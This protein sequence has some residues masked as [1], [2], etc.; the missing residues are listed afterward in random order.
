MDFDPTRAGVELPDEAL[1]KKFDVPAPRYTSYPTADRFHGRITPEDYQAALARREK[2][3]KPAKLSLY[4]HIPFCNDVCFY[5]GCNKIVTR[6]HSRSAAYIKTL[7]KEADLA[8]EHLTGIKTLEQLH[9]GGGTPTFLNDDEI[10][11]LMAGLNERFPFEEGGE[12]S[13]EVDPRSCPPSKIKTLRKAGFNRMSLG[14]QDFNPDV[15]KAVNR[16]QPFEM[17]KEVLESARAEGFGSINMDLIYGLPRQTRET[18]ARTIEQVI[19][20]SPDRIALYHYAHL[21]N[22]FKPQRRIIPA[23][24]PGAAERVN[25]MFDA[26]KT[27]T[28]HGYRYI[29]MDHF[30]KE[31]DELSIAQVNGTIQRNFQ[32]Y[33]TRAECDMVALGP[34][35]ISF[36]D[37]LY[38]C[39]PREIEPWSEAIESGKLATCRGFD[40][41]DDDKLRRAV[42]M[43]IMCR[44]ELDK[45]EIEEE[46][47]IEFDEY[48]AYE[49][50]K[51]QAY[52]KHELAE[53]TADKIIVSPKGKIFVRAVAMQFDRY[54]RESDR[55]G[56]YSK[57]A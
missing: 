18:F 51:L 29:G 17:T 37:G 2:A 52:V 16:I 20:L 23:E 43:T 1:L 31:T 36:V 7:L 45:R 30:A 50:K 35:S 28:S 33:S 44:F 55:A 53:L 38:A 19:E 12:F 40:L 49:M 11:E 3:A 46:F 4:C 24:L 21:P 6:D 54:L 32:G 56:G 26:I 5:C 14:V 42:I 27:L 39:N 57:I 47:G 22:I 8:K 25:I 34:S 48:F 15:Q 13:I 9:W 10:L 41:N